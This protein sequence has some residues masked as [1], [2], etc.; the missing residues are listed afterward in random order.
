MAL[1]GDHPRAVV[2]SSRLCHR[3]GTSLEVQWDCNQ[4]DP[5]VVGS[6]PGVGLLEPLLQEEVP[7]LEFLQ[8]A[9]LLELL[10]QVG[11]PP[12]LLLQAVLPLHEVARLLQLEVAHQLW[13]FERQDINI[14]RKMKPL[15]INV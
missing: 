2:P 3:Q 6:P 14:P 8:V 12:G 4:E 15:S 7:L 5:P 11:A 9:V 13:I 10:L 1:D